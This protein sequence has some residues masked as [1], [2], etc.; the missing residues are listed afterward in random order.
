MPLLVTG[1]IHIDGFSDTMDALSSHAERQKKLEIM[2]DPHI[3]AFGVRWIIVYMM[4]Y[5]ASY[6]MKY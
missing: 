4:I 5:A 1:G 3:G 6:L 2:D